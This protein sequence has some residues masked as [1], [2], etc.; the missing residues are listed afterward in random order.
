MSESALTCSR[1]ASRAAACS[2]V[3]SSTAS[4]A[5]AATTKK[6]APYR[7]SGR[8]VKTVTSLAGLPPSASITK[9][10]CA[11][12]ERPIQFF[13]MAR[14][15]SGQWPLQLVHVIEQPVRVLGDLEVP[16]VQGLLGDGGA[17]AF[18][19]TVDHLFVGQHGL[20]LGAPVDRRILAVG[21]AALVEA[22]EQPLGPAV[23][24]RVRGVQPA[25]PVSGDGVALERR[26]LG[27]DV[28]VGPLA[29]VGVAL[30]GGVLGGQAE[31]VPADRVQD[32]VALL[33]QVARHDVAHGE[34]LGVA[35]VQ[36]AR[37]VREHVQHVAAL[38]GAVVGGREDLEVL[39]HLRPLGLHGREA[40][41]TLF[42][43]SAATAVV[44]VSVSG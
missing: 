18:A 42:G 23:V 24:L 31:G 27:V 36:V 28:G 39:P 11:P 21:Q 20:V 19:G 35:H 30:D 44:P 6:V 16:L 17:A 8:V 43:V 22:L 34:R 15:R 12:S 33:A 38:A 32:V 10:T 41:G 1:Y 14:T 37:G 5:S 3:T 7:V 4:G 26:R 2:S 9:L 25:G 40:V 13:C 29:G